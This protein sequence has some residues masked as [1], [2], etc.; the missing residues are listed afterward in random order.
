MFVLSVTQYLH[1]EGLQY[2]MRKEHNKNHKEGEEI[3]CKTK[4][5]NSKAPYIRQEIKEYDCEECKKSYKGKQAEEHVKKHLEAMIK[6]KSIEESRSNGQAP[7][8]LG[9]LLRNIP[10][11][12][13][14]EVM[15]K[16]QK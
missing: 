12:C 14:S 3:K 1:A 4:K 7:G 2:N 10:S 13:T 15:A 16:P 5:K 9:M 6:G 8:V 11:I